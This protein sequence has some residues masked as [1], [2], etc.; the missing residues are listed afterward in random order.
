MFERTEDI[1]NFFDFFRNWI[2]LLVD[3]I[4]EVLTYYGQKKEEYDA[5]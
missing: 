3:K 4:Q 1:A 5:L 2:K